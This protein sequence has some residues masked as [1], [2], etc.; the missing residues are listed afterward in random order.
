MKQKPFLI[1]IAGP[2]CSGKTTLAHAVAERLTSADASGRP[3]M[4]LPQDA[5][6]KDLSTLPL[7]ER[8]R[9]NFDEP[10]AFDWALME[11]HLRNLAERRPVERPI[12]DFTTHTRREETL[13]MAPSAYVIIEGLLA[14]HS[15][16]IRN[17]L[18][19][20]VF[21]DAPDTVCLERRIQRDTQSRGRTRESVERQF[22]ETVQPMAERYVRPVRAF[23]D[24][25]IDGEADIENGAAEVLAAL[26]K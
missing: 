10:A 21:V 1:G 22:R 25:V 18:A 6:Y 12:Y 26:A 23:A 9:N 7:E 24:L 14:F 16:A 20:R 4:V 3:V 15:P 13:T 2:S 17:L 19:L 11:Q 5:Y 8:A